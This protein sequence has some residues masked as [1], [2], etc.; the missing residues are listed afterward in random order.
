MLILQIEHRIFDFDMWKRAFDG[1][2]LD[3]KGSGVRRHR[4]ARPIDNPNYVV[5]DLG[6]D[7]VSEAEAFL[8][9]LHEKVWRSREASPALAS[10][11]QT[12]IVEELE[13]DEY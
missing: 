2:P 4:I 3:R 1:D 9:G 10:P 5:L 11:P 12:R 8:E 7:S 13:V 6:F